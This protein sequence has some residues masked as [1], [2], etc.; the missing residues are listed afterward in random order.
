MKPIKATFKFDNTGLG[1]DAAASDFNNHWWERVYNDAA[2]NVQVS[3][4]GGSKTKIQTQDVDAV[5]ISTSS[6]NYKKMKKK[7]GKTSGFGS[8]IKTAT[9]TNTGTE[10]AIDGQVNLDEFRHDTVKP[11]TDE[12][13]FAACGGRTAHKGARHGLK[14]SGKLARLA[15]QDAKLLYKLGPQPSTSKSVAEDDDAEIQSILYQGDYSKKLSKRKKKTHSRI[16]NE[17]SESL[18]SFSLQSPTQ[19]VE[20]EK[21]HR[22]NDQHGGVGIQ[23]RKK[24]SKKL[25]EKLSKVIETIVEDI[26]GSKSDDDVPKRKEKSSSKKKYKSDEDVSEVQKNEKKSKKKEKIYIEPQGDED[27][28]M[29]ED[30]DVTELE[31]SMLD[32]QGKY[33]A[34]K[35]RLAKDMK[36]KRKRNRDQKAEKKLAKAL[37]VSLAMNVD[38]DEEQ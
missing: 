23:K 5:D 4:D 36:P 33:S 13:L 20:D 35:K 31:D 38:D 7:H 17:L 26:R 9:L 6:I 15:E 25:K 12:E 19:E 27:N 29:E 11:L 32:D 14:L 2:S 30:T 37:A 22:L 10:D 1:H 18:D 24:K 34:K 21:F 3:S 8:F 16:D 28:D